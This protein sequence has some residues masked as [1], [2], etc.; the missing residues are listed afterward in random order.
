ME[1][2]ELLNKLLEVYSKYYDISLINDSETGLA[3]RCDFH[4][5]NE[6]YVLVKSAKLWEADCH[7]Y[8]F[9]F[10]TEHFTEDFFKASRDYV[11]S[12][13][14]KLIVP[15]EG[16]M[17]TYVTAVFICDDFDKEGVRLLK[18]SKRYKSYR[19][20][21]WGWSDFRTYLIRSKD[22][23]LFYNRSGKDA[24]KFVKKIN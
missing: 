9:V 5:H 22:K 2:K 1:R 19:F 16:H 17:Y 13:A 14:D 20:S 8:V 12:E 11:F 24:A 10:L 7:E 23:A 4:I 3:A 18:K 15:K 21:L 6:K